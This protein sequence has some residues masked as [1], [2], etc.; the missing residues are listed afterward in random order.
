MPASNDVLRLIGEMV[1]GDNGLGKFRGS[2]GA[3]IFMKAGWNVTAPCPNT[4]WETWASEQLREW[5]QLDSK[6]VEKLLEAM[7][8]PDEFLEKG[9]VNVIE[10]DRQLETWNGYLVQHGLQIW[11]ADVGPARVGSITPGFL[12]VPRLLPATSD[13]S[14]PPEI[15]A[16]LAAFRQRF[17]NPD[18]CIFIMMQFGA[19]QPIKAL[20]ETVKAALA[21]NGYLGLRADDHKFA[22]LLWINIQT[23]MHACRAG[24][25]LFERV[26]NN[27]HNANIALEAGYMVA[28]RKR[29]GFLKDRTK[30]LQSDLTGHIWHSFDVN[31]PASIEP[32]VEEWLRA[33]Q[34]L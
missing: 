6:A 11:A 31:V 10:R 28:L 19:S 1:V 16:S 18:K 8:S 34:L 22:D 9:R 4:G 26:E 7:A 15:I 30:E 5:L 3:K 29:V 32:A 13:A 33:D 20:A 2:D 12:S 27:N 14:T 25:A 17:S 21:K 23:Y 24:I